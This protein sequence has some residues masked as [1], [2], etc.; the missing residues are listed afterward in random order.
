MFSHPVLHP[1]VQN[2]MGFHFDIHNYPRGKEAKYH[3]PLTNYQMFGQAKNIA[4][5]RMELGV[6]GWLSS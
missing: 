6:P 5:I 3:Y 2:H 4:Q 1:F